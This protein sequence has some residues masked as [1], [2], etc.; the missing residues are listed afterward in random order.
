MTDDYMISENGFFFTDINAPDFPDT[1]YG[2]LSPPGNPPT[3][4]P[5]PGVT[6]LEDNK[7]VKYEDDE[8]IMD[9]FTYV[10]DKIASYL[11]TNKT[12]GKMILFTIN[13]TPG[14]ALDPV[15][16]N[17][18]YQNFADTGTVGSLTDDIPNTDIENYDFTE[19]EIASIG[20]HGELIPA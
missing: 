17:A 7:V 12:T 1:S 14:P 9:H 4:P 15:G 3:Q 5:E 6:T 8:I 13:R 20:P 11:E 16:T 19:T 18:D 10:G 2:D